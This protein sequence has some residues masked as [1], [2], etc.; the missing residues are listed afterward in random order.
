MR[1]LVLA[2][3]F[4]LRTVLRRRPHL[5]PCRV[6]CHQCRIF[7]LAHPRNR[8]RK[9]LSCP[10]GCR[11]S[12]RR[13]KSSERSTAYYRTAAGKKKKELLNGRRRQA[14]DSRSQP[15]VES[16]G[17]EAEEIAPEEIEFNK[18]IVDHVVVVTSLIE[19]FAVS[20]EAVL[21]MLAKTMRQRSLF[22]ERRLDYFLGWLAEHFP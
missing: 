14:G 9:D 1:D 7:F 5:R 2:Y 19:G 3:Y 22:R 10:F 15:A 4:V 18:G 6:R 21:A 13:K 12:N 20:Q 11:K 16:A 17:A 8:G